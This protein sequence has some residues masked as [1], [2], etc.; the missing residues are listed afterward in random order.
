MLPPP[1]DCMH[2]LS[3]RWYEESLLYFSCWLLETGGLERITQ[4]VCAPP[5][6]PPSPPE[7]CLHSL[8]ARWMKKAYEESLLY[9]SCW[10]L[11]TGGLER[12]TQCVCAPLP[13][14]P[15]PPPPSPHTHTLCFPPK[16][17]EETHQVGLLAFYQRSVTYHCLHKM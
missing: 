7:D 1:E 3:A 4:C 8:S 9:F 5:P 6:P 17:L 14:P 13:P 12:T 10:L 16:F 11:E 15:P 2:S